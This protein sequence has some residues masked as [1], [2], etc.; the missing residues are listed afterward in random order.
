MYLVLY[1]LK[2]RAHFCKAADLAEA[3]EAAEALKLRGA[4]DVT[5]VPDPFA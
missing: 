3:L 2:G 4:A 1:T 5:V